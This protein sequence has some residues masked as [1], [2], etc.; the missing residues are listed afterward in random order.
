MVVMDEEGRGGVMGGLCLGSGLMYRLM[1]RSVSV[2][3]Y[4][5][6]GERV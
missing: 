4:C 3:K 5:I 1:R 6:G 2:A